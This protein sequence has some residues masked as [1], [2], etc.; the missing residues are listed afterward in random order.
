MN[1]KAGIAAIRTIDLIVRFALTLLIGLGLLLVVPSKS[2]DWIGSV[3]AAG[4]LLSLLGD[5]ARV[6]LKH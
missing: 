1:I 2:V 3:V 6:A 4:F 5:V